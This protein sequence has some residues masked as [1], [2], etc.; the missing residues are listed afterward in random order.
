[1]AD[2]WQLGIWNL[3]SNRL[4]W[5]FD[6][7]QGVSADN[8]ALRF[9]PDDRQF[10]FATSGEACV[11]DLASGR[12]VQSWPLPPGL[13]QEL[14]W[15]K[16][17]HLL[18]VQWEW[19]R[20]GRCR[21]RDL[22]APGN[23][24]I[25]KVIEDFEGRVLD[26]ALSDDGQRLAIMGTFARGDRPVVKIIEPTTGKEFSC[27]P[28]DQALTREHFAV[29]PDVELVSSWDWPGTSSDLW[30]VRTGRSVGKV[31]GLADALSPRGHLVASV[32][33]PIQGGVN[34]WRRDRPQSWIACGLGLRIP[35][36]PRFSPDG[37]YLAYGTGEGTVQVCDLAESVR[38][39][40]TLG[41]GWETRDR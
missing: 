12:R 34:L 25:V 8:A 1:L 22:D 21:V 14:S 39:L 20:D 18:H 13:A 24:V 27:F 23:P 37:R 32:G 35:Q 19:R 28:S 5:V 3:A 26:L 4:D 7:P 10:A 29:D 17:G 30:D 6:T 38:R 9:S 2:N 36:F 40:N 15:N 31:S 11:W 33:D 41:L 16:T